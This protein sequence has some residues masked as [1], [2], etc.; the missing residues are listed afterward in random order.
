M[1]KAQREFAAK[2]WTLT[3]ILALIFVLLHAMGCKKAVVRMKSST[4]MS[5]GRDIYVPADYATPDTALRNAHAGD[6][7]YVN[8]QQASFETATGLVVPDGVDLIGG[9]GASAAPETIIDYT[10]SARVPMIEVGNGASVQGFTFTSSGDA[11]VGVRILAGKNVAIRNN[12]FKTN[13]V[14]VTDAGNVTIEGNLIVPDFT[15]G[16]IG[17]MVSSSGIIVSRSNN[18][19]IRKNTIYGRQNTTFA[20]TIGIALIDNT[21][22]VVEENIVVN[23]ESG[24]QVDDV[25]LTTATIQYNCVWNN[26]AYGF[27]ANFYN[28][29]TQAVF[30]PTGAGNISTDPLFVSVARG[31]GDFRLLPSSPCATA[32]KNGGIIGAREVRRVLAAKIVSTP[33]GN[34]GTWLEALRFEVSAGDYDAEF[35]GA[36]W[37]LN[38]TPQYIAAT[39]SIIEDGTRRDLYTSSRMTGGSAGILVSKIAAHT[40][41]EYVVYLDSAGLAKGT[42]I[43]VRLGP[44][45]YQ[46]NGQAVTLPA[47]PGNTLTIQ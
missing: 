36:S 3:T 6:N 37:S 46:E 30:T 40:S 25:T 22:A 23:G 17:S 44:T 16:T 12:V 26:G 35:N 27:P 4:T 11:T 10:G 15:T 9:A 39:I 8:R 5:Q 14:Q 41:R 33:P 13:G 47:I 31:A 2:I 7:V 32:G 24:L 29:N 38:T 19:V 42:V 20:P 45:Y 28:S 43:Q 34:M 21:N 18:T 1:T